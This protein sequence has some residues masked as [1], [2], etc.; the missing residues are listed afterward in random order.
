MT[1]R[2][3]GGD[4]GPPPR[5][6]GQEQQ[7]IAGRVAEA[8][9]AAVMAVLGVLHGERLCPA[10][11]GSGG[12]AV[13]GLAVLV[14]LS[15]SSSGPLS[16]RERHVPV[17]AWCGMLC[18]APQRVKHV[19]LPKLREPLSFCTFIKSL[20]ELSSA[21]VHCSSLVKDHLNGCKGTTCWAGSVACPVC[22]FGTCGLTRLCT[23]AAAASVAHPLP[24]RTPHPLALLFASC[25]ILSFS[26]ILSSSALTKCISGS[27]GMC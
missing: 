27:K 23:W 18:A 14:R 19:A 24:S 10:Q 16:R 17:H 11:Q 3:G 15:P 26:C 21:Q 20:W 7:P 22:C 5:D 9:V 2:S 13:A 12:E 25:P 4:R 8:D 1:N 6:D